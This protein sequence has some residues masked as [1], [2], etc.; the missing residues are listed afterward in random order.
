M[1]AVAKRIYEPSDPADGRRVLVDR[2]WPRG[3]A[4]EGAAFD[5][6]LPEVAP[7]TELRTWFGHE[8][9][10]WDEFRHR[11][12]AELDGNAAFERLRA[13]AATERVTLLYSARD[14]AH[15]QAVALADML[16]DA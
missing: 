8:P 16:N 6:W 13:E 3:L 15:N 12:Q 14:E 1:G 5:E 7:S 11:Y 9:S 10:R 2:I 4:K